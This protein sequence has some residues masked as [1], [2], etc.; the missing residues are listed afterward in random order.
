[1]ITF[2]KFLLGIDIALVLQNNV[3]IL[4]EIYFQIFG[5]FGVP[6]S[7]YCYKLAY[8]GHLIQVAVWLLVLPPDLKVDLFLDRCGMP[9]YKFS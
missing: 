9:K 3:Q 1:M 2:R 4:E 6:R 8:M 7:L 5:L